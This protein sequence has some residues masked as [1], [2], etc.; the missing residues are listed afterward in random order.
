MGE[1]V[2]ANG[3][4]E[5]PGG[6][7][8]GFIDFYVLRLSN[9]PISTSGYSSLYVP[10]KNLV[11]PLCVHIIQLST[12]PMRMYSRHTLQEKTQYLNR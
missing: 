2:K 1:G 12:E 5:V 6:Y 3:G 10:C 4:G 8:S 11:R 9:S 7:K